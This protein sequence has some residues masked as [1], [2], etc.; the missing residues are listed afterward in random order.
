[1]VA[2]SARTF[3]VPILAIERAKNQ[4]ANDAR[5]AAMAFLKDEEGWTLE[6][7]GAAMNRD[8]STVIHNLKRHDALL[9]TDPV[10]RDRYFEMEEAL[11][12]TTPIE[13]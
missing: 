8:H 11:F 9:E 13:V 10:Y 7:V 2:T 6:Q 5:R 4:R 3:A 1:M 12:P